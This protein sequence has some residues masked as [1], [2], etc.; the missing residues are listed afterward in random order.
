MK[1]LTSFLLH[2]SLAILLFSVPTFS[3]G[4]DTIFFSIP[5]VNAF[6]GDT[7]RIPL[8]VSTLLFSDSIYS[9]DITLSYDT[10]VVQI[11]GVKADTI[12]SHGSSLFFNPSLKKIGFASG[13]RIVGGGVLLKLVARLRS[14]STTSSPINFVSVLLNEGGF[15]IN[16]TNGEIN[17]VNQNPQIVAFPDTIFRQ[18]NALIK[19][20]V[21]AFDGDFELLSFS[22]QN[23]PSGMT[24]LPAG[25]TQNIFRAEISWIPG[26]NQAGTYP[27][28]LVVIDNKG[29]FASK[30]ITYRIFDVNRSPVFSIPPRDTTIDE[31]TLLTMSVK[32]VDAD[33]DSIIY[34][35]SGAPLGMIINPFGIISWKPNFAQAGIYTFDVTAGDT[36]GLP[37]KA[38]VTVTVINVNQPPQFTS[39]MRDTVIYDTTRLTFKY[40]AFDPDNDEIF[41]SLLNGPQGANIDLG[42]NFNFKPQQNQLGLFFIIVQVKDGI[43]TAIDTARIL[44]LQSNNSPFFTKGL[45][46]TT[47][48]AN[49][50]FIF[51]YSASD[52]DIADT[53]SFGLF[54][55]PQGANISPK[56]LLSWT[57]SSFQAG[58]NLIIVGVTDGKGGTLD[59]AIVSVQNVNRSPKFITTLPDIFVPVDT[60]LNFKYSAVD[61]DNDNLTFSLI[62]FPSGATIQKD[63]IFSW[64]PSAA[65]LGRDT[66]IAAVTDGILIVQ[67]TSIVSVIGFPSVSFSPNNIDFGSINFGGSKILPITITNSGITSL[68]IVLQQFNLQPD[69]N[70]IIDTTGISSIA[71][72]AQ[73]TINV[74]YH[75][76]SVGGHNTA[77]GFKTNDPKNQ[78]LLV[79]ANGA[80]IAKLAVAKKLLVDTLHNSSLSF[81]D[82]T[83]GISQLFKFF[84]QSGIQISLTGSLLSPSGND[85]LLLIAPQKNFSRS[86]IDSVKKFVTNGG[87]LIALGNS[88][89]EGNNTAALNSLLKD[90]TWTTNLALDSNVVVDPS[91]FYSDTLAPMLT[92]FVDAKHP[93]FTNVDTLVFFGSASVT[94]LGTAVPLI[95]TTPKGKTIGGQSRTQP[96]VAGLSK[97]GKGKILLLGDADVWYVG[98]AKQQAQPNISIKDNLTFAINVFSVTEDYEVKLPNKTFN[99]RYQLVSIPFDLE[100]SDVASVLK[101]LGEQ[102]PLVWRL[103]GRYDPATL[104]YAEFPSEKFKSFKRGEAYW[105]ITRGEFGLSLGNSTIVPVQAFYPIKIGSGYSMVGNPFPYKV[106]WKNSLHDSTQNLIWKFDGETFKAESL[107]LDPFI[108]YFVKNLAKDSVTI[109]INPEDITS[110]KKSAYSAAVYNEGEW[111]ISIGAASGKS[112]DKENYAGVA[113][114]A[115]D[116]FDSY[117]IAEP[118]SSP[119]DYVIVRFQNNSW[120]EHSGSYAMDIRSINSEGLFWDFDVITAASQ[121]RVALNLKQIG[122]LP[123]DFV[124]YVIDK[125]TERVIR[126]DQTYQYEFSMAKNESRRNFRLIAGKKEFIEK[127]TQGIPLV[128][129]DYSLVQNY[130]NPFNPSTQIRY[131]IGH[132][133]QVSLDVYNV[134]GQHVRSLVNAIQ[135]IGT[136]ELEWDGKDNIGT[137]VST[138]VYFYKITVTTNGERAFTETKKLMLLK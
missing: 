76:K 31:N 59:T 103:F 38:S 11:L 45:P 19:D 116:E 73:K 138:G 36:K 131:T 3:S 63:G 75:P 47:I 24:I 26:F 7:V 96:V 89:I 74:T 60:I 77:Y 123:N 42:G 12:L 16:T 43:S 14:T 17:P 83:R 133:G 128:A 118:P 106:S 114:G 70:F 50:P 28:T 120:K 23:A 6:R 135:P 113:K 8:N 81:T 58:I 51:Q 21:S 71:P 112:S 69:P 49:S 48:N 95:T 79:N 44:I 41:F 27:V 104:K 93:Y 92:T 55:G 100:N 18:E 129:V 32:A 20:T 29:G 37:T 25:S 22:L 115:K 39:T 53:L 13:I 46:D 87:L 52:V 119:T 121:S 56:G 108:G 66:I 35:L 94:V 9:G 33:N 137:T 68:N 105:L 54:F 98:S 91:S 107:A 15:I 122:N 30:V 84:E 62:K 101:G 97:I 57:P 130:P 78:L 34:G 99:E 40:S 136:Y 125:T 102:N 10:T 109:Y 72:G 117:D 61:P 134:L 126:I 2:T 65:Q 90:T 110:L 86:E 82:S 111:R 127:N 64:K 4:T 5:K 88:A 80:A 124:I 132:S 1:T 67:D 85:I